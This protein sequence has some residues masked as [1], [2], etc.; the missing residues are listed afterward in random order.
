[1]FRPAVRLIA[2][3]AVA[4]V[5]AACADVPSEPQRA[6]D[7]A[8]SAS[9]VAGTCT[10]LAGLNALALLVFGDGTSNVSS[11]LGKLS[12]LDN[13]VRG[14]RLRQ[15]V[16]RAHDIVDFTLKQFASGSLT[17]TEAELTAFLNKV[18][19]FAGLDIVINE[20]SNTHLIL[21]SDQEQIKYAVDQQ[22][23]IK[24]EANPVSEPTLIEFQQLP[25]DYEPGEGP[26]D[27]K[28][29]QYPGF[30]VI[31]KSSETD[32]PLLKPA[33]VGVCASGVIPADVRANLRLGHGAS[34]GFEIAP[35]AEADFL[36]CENLDG[37]EEAVSAGAKLLRGIAELV[38]PRKA[39]ARFQSASRGGGVGGTV[40]E[41]SPFAPVDTRLSAGGGVGGTVT[42]FSRMPML[43]DPFSVSVTPPETCT[44]STITGTAYSPVS[45]TCR[46]FIRLTTRLGTVFNDVPV[47]WDVTAGGG[48]IAVDAASV[49]GPYASQLLTTTDLFGR[50]AVCWKLGAPGANQVRAT[51]GI[52]GDAVPG[53]TFEPAFVTFDAT[54]AAPHDAGHPALITI[55]QGNGQT[56]T[57]GTP[58]PI[59]PQVRVTDNYGTPVA[60]AKVRWMIVLGRGSLSR[61]SVLTD[62]NGLASVEW[63]LGLGDNQLKAYIDEYVFAYVYFQGTGT[64]AP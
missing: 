22:S 29:D 32:A 44:L 45:E 57:E 31:T 54:A 5:V 62:A 63:T 33:V 3:A 60:G 15:A 40:T 24:F 7:G 49:C 37:T 56:A 13:H 50:S 41:F 25:N 52:G 55:T 53:V 8:A 12:N 9:I 58:T 61:T 14:G 38:L 18:Y 28:L 46:P 21:P 20:P 64:T 34:T 36:D 11:V 42:E 51:P 26:L 43:M 16:S 17:G 2:A 4:V 59:A 47:T 39:H 23:A 35:D 48:L 27:T 1:M 30:I 6:V 10:D 19:C